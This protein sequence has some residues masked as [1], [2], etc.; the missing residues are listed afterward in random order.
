[1]SFFSSR[2]RALAKTGLSRSFWLAVFLG[3]T[4]LALMAVVLIAGWLTHTTLQ[5]VEL[6]VPPPG[7][8]I[9]AAGEW[10]HVRCRGSA[11]APTVVLESGVMGWSSVWAWFFKGDKDGFR[12]CA[13]DRPGLGWSAPTKRPAD[14]ESSAKVLHAVTRRLKIRKPFVL[15]GHS[16]GGLYAL[17]YQR[18]YPGDVSALVLVDPAH[19]QQLSRLPSRTV[20]KTVTSVDRLQGVLPLLDFGAARGALQ[21]TSSTLR[22][23][24]PTE[25]QDIIHISSSQLH[26]RRSIKEYQAF[27]LTAAQTKKT[28]SVDVP[29]LVISTSRREPGDRAANESWWALH[30]GLATLSDKGVWTAI[31]E[32]THNSVIMDQGNAALVWERIQTLIPPATKK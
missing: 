26:L 23:L 29:L 27:P 4:I 8:V 13:W 22:L 9:Y 20:M 24:P 32:S 1:M 21:A 19:P 15:V 14:A 10:V 17:V 18:L 7:R 12:I 6:S 2:R 28:T 16:L 3:W 25:Q 30:Q 31:P 11:T 5:R